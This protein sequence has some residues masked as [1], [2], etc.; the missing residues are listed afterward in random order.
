MILYYFTQFVHKYHYS[1]FMIFLFTLTFHGRVPVSPLIP[2]NS[3]F[4][5]R[6]FIGGTYPPAL[7]EDRC[8]S[9]EKERRFQFPATNKRYCFELRAIWTATNLVT[10]RTLMDLDVSTSENKNNPT[11]QN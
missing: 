4:A 10:T 1:I 7:D 6:G 5:Q 3:K 11:L 9:R 2:Y 8:S